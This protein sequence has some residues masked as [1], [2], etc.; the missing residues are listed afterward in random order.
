MR[1]GVDDVRSVAWEYTRAS[2]LWNTSLLALNKQNQHYN[3]ITTEMR[4]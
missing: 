2:Q 3:T 4:A 1:C